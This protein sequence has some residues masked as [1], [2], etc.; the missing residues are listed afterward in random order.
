MNEP[1]LHGKIFGGTGTSDWYGQFAIR[2]G[3]WF[4]S[5]LDEEDNPTELYGAG[6]TPKEAFERLVFSWTFH[7]GGVESA[8]LRSLL[9]DLRSYFREDGDIDHQFYKNMET[10]VG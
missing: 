6:S 4:F 5:F 3:V 2:N 1:W 7:N 8:N 10:S 9:P